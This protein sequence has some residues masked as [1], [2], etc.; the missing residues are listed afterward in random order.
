MGFVNTSASMN[1]LIE[2]LWKTIKT[3]E[4]N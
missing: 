3:P 4:E 1:P 2:E